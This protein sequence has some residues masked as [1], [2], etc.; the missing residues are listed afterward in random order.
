ML[1][2]DFLVA[3]DALQT[4]RVAEL[5]EAYSD[6]LRQAVTYRYCLLSALALWAEDYAKLNRA[7][8]R[9]RELLGATPWHPE[10]DVD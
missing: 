5:E 4:A 1:T 9:I 6:A 3:T 8:N 2:V 7:E 10:N